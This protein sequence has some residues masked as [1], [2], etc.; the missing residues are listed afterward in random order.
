[1]AD[2]IQQ[3]IDTQK[4]LTHAVSHELRTPISRIRF[5]LEMLN[6]ASL[7]TDRKHYIAEIVKDI[8][9]LEDLVA[10]SLAY[11]QFEHG[12]PQLERQSRILEPW[13]QQIAHTV[14]KSHPQIKYQCL[15]LISEPER[16]VYLEPRYMA[17]AIGNL[18]QNAAN[19]A[20]SRID[21]TL[22]EN[23]EECVIQV[24]DDGS[25]IPEAD[26]RR[27]F[28]AFIRLESSRSR[29]SGGYGLGLAIVQRV[30]TW[31]GGR[32][33]ATDAPLGGARFTIRWPGFK[34]QNHKGSTNSEN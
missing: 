4:E 21:V 23:Q 28:N 9:D 18:L 13:L 16:T 31:H 22:S 25:G 24:D 10:E 14:L 3:L 7:V 32:A 5:S 33:S 34:Q 6:G 26:R 17:R 30:A 27:V 19:H 20:K 8:N 2:R 15:N 12:D 11:A 1:M 29:D